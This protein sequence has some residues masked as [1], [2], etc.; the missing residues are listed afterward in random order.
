MKN[1]IQIILLAS[2][3]ILLYQACYSQEQVQMKIQKGH[4]AAIVNADFSPDGKKLASIGGF[5]DGLLLIWDIESGRELLNI[6]L[7]NNNLQSVKFSSDGKLIIVTDDNEPAKIID[8]QSGNIIREHACKWGE[9]YGEFST[10]NAYYMILC[11]EKTYVYHTPTGTLVAA[12]S[13]ED[14]RPES[15]GFSFD[16][17]YIIVAYREQ[18]GTVRIY[19]LNNKMK[20]KEISHVDE[21][22]NNAFFDESNALFYTSGNFLKTWSL[23]DF[24]EKGKTK[25]ESTLILSRDRLISAIPSTW[26]E[27]VLYDVKSN[28][29]I[30]EIPETEDIVFSPYIFTRKKKRNYYFLAI[31]RNY[32][33]VYTDMVKNYADF[34]ELSIKG[35]NVKARKIRRFEGQVENINTIACGNQKKLIC[36]G[37]FYLNVWDMFALKNTHRYK[38][39]IQPLLAIDI[40]SSA[41]NFVAST[42]YSYVKVWNTD[43][44][45]AVKNYEWDK[46]HAIF[47][48]LFSSD[49]NQLLA[50]RKDDN[51]MIWDLERDMP[52]YNFILSK[53][54]FGASEFSP[55]G[56]YVAIPTW[57]SVFIFNTETR[58]QEQ[59]LKRDVHEPVIGI[60]YSPDNKQ[61]L[62]YCE[63]EE[64]LVL[65][66]IKTGEILKNYQP[67][68]LLYDFTPDGKSI[69]VYEKKNFHFLDVN[70]GKIYSSIASTHEVNS[71]DFTKDQRYLVSSGEGM[72]RFWDLKTG[73]EVISILH[74]YG[75]NPEYVVYTPDAYYMST[76]NGIQGVHFLLN[77]KVYLFDQFDVKYNRPD[78]I[79]ERLGYASE[80]LI[81][82]YHQAY[83]K[84]LRKM[85]FTE[86][87]LNGDFH[88]PKSRIKNFEYMPVI[89]EETIEIDLNFEDDKYNLD[90]YNIRINEVPVFGMH[91]ISLRE[92]KINTFSV[93][94]SLKLSQGRNRIEVSCL[95]EKGA[96]SFKESVEIAYAPKKAM[97]A[98]VYFIGIG[99]DTYAE[100]GHNLNYSVKDIRDL[101]AGFREKYG[102]KLIVDTLFDAQVDCEKVM[103]LKTKLLQSNINDKVII[104]FSGHGLL[105]KDFDYYLAMHNTNFNQPEMGGL[106]YEDLEWLLDSIPARKKLLLIDAC[107]SGEVDKE[108]LLAMQSNNQENIKGATLTYTYKPA[109]GMK[110]SFELMQ[111][112]FANLNKGTGGTVISAAAGTQFAY[113]KE[114]LSNGVFTYSI[115]ELMKTQAEMTVNQLKEQVGKRVEELTNGLQKPTSRV[116]NLEFEWR[117]W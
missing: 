58:K 11:Y 40:D 72:I 4:S 27:S 57:D 42:S 83:L 25:M 92:L 34:Y 106:P 69:V 38:D 52:T 20:I 13:N 99:V 82:A 110:N 45:T 50:G 107:H 53:Q 17:Q 84:R 56:K 60:K 74:I 115:L 29:K 116:E 97:Q 108:E 31:P 30:I 102:N 6:K 55:Y 88:I 79:L 75:R 70:S 71:F 78:I 109:L 48:I 15:A 47:Q 93:K 12:F 95:N 33:V 105:S 28:K 117:V 104:A 41:R 26:D 103:A 22:L 68:S 16:N 9:Y 96:E 19:D 85:G 21:A 62:S 8:V 2:M 65:W 10:D 49:G 66:D 43:H 87:D 111:E 61:I 3:L 101:C 73:K 63:K 18:E 76:K 80:S 51:A 77:D 114:A 24:Q 32:V 94:E 67:A 39:H 113:E 90:R 44:D 14:M 5:G 7:S 91:G 59:I 54:T 112:L 46:S 1:L 98:K 86:E 64:M 37:D 36:G 81:D 100:A 35:K 23:K 89:E